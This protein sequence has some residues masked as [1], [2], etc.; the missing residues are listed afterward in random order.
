MIEKSDKQFG[1]SSDELWEHRKTYGYQVPSVDKPKSMDEVGR[2]W[3]S[4]VPNKPQKSSLNATC[5]PLA[6]DQGGG[7]DCPFAFTILSMDAFP[8]I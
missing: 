8:I 1:I 5:P 2:W 3:T 7:L 4:K 6:G